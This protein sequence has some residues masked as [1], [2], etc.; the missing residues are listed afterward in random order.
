MK[1]KKHVL[2]LGLNDKDTKQQEISTI[3]AYKIVTRATLAAGYEGA[4]ITEA[5]GIYTHA[6]GEVV[7]EK[8]LEIGLLF[9]DDSRTDALI[10]ELKVLF[11]QESIALQKMTI[12]SALV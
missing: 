6:A 8:S 10:K 9:A 4:T 12:E 2:Y 1:I 11:N 3:D 5:T 7:I